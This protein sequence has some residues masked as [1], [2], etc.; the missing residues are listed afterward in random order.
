MLFKGVEQRGAKLPATRKRAYGNRGGAEAL[1]GLCAR[2]RLMVLSDHNPIERLFTQERISKRQARWLETLCDFDFR[3]E[4]IRG[5]D[6]KAAD[7][8][9]RQLYA[10]NESASGRLPAE[11]C[12]KILPAKM[13][14]LAPSISPIATAALKRDELS[15][16]TDAR[17]AG[18]CF[19]ERICNPSAPR[20]VKSGLLRFDSGLCAPQGRLRQI[21]LR[22]NHDDKTAGHLRPRKSMQKLKKQYCWPNMTADAHECAASCLPRQKKASAK[23]SKVYSSH[24]KRPSAN[25]APLA[26]LSLREGRDEA[27][28]PPG[29][30]TRA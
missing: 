19:Q 22:E 14:A 2:K 29:D 3:I 11:A 5:K 27:H 20:E 1:E 18:G 25:G 17:H 23:E 13:H 12:N 10:S 7:A 9:S 24:C 4:R 6:G 16:I 8:L 21:L 30:S 28:A 26:L 15:K